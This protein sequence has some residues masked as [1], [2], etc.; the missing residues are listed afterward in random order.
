MVLNFAWQKA[1]IRSPLMRL[2][3][4]ILFVFATMPLYGTI[5]IHSHT[6][7]CIITF[8]L[9]RW[10][11]FTRCPEEFDFMTMIRKKHE[12]LFQIGLNERHYDRF[13]ACLESAMLSAGI[14]RDLVEEASQRLMPIRH[15]FSDSYGNWR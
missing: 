4:P 7:I 1:G 15:V 2:L 3:I 10:V 13:M 11:L 14:Q 12:R 9:Y 5:Y 8:L 6:I